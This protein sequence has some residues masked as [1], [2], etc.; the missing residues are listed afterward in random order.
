MITI[1]ELRID[2]EIWPAKGK[3]TILPPAHDHV[4]IQSMHGGEGLFTDTFSTNREQ[5]QF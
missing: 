4:L 5:V 3:Q 1:C 2:S